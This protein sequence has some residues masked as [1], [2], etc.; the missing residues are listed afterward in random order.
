MAVSVNSG[1]Q[2]VVRTNS[3]S[4]TV[5]SGSNRYLRGIVNHE[6][7]ETQVPPTA[8]TWNG[9][10][11]TKVLEGKGTGGFNSSQM[12]ELKESDI[13]DT[14]L[15]GTFSVSGHS[16]PD[17][18]SLI[19]ICYNGVDQT[20]P[21]RDSAEVGL[22]GNNPDT[23][24]ILDI[25]D[26]DMVEYSYA[27]SGSLPITGWFNE[28]ASP[29]ATVQDDAG[30][31]PSEAG[32]KAYSG[33]DITDGQV[34]FSGGTFSRCPT[35]VA[36]LAES[37]G[38]TYTLSCD[39]GTFTQTGTAATLIKTHKIS[40]ATDQYD[41]TGVAASLEYGRVIDAE[42]VAYVLSGTAAS[43]EK[44]YKL[45]AESGTFIQIGTDA[46]LLKGYKI[47]P[48]NGPY[49][50][51]G[52]DVNLYRGYLVSAETTAYTYTGFP[53]TLIYSA[54]GD[55]SI[56]AESGTFVATG[57]DATL[58]LGRVLSAASTA[59]N[60]AGTDA[61][62]LKGRGLIAES[63]TFNLVGKDISLLSN[64]VLTPENGEYILTGFDVAD[65]FTLRE[66]VYLTTPITREKILA[67]S[68]TRTKELTN[69]ITREKVLSTKILQ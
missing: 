23:G 57:A 69:T 43:L 36:I 13:A 33:S 25:N 41:V 12:W 31:D 64:R 63:G 26:G 58:K 39:S 53:A 20:T 2:S 60:V 19:M 9:K 30:D 55:K 51:S 44:G 15:S 66:V 32:Y 18:V 34:N 4:F 38:T 28:I 27:S 42:T 67:T 52:Q 10:S 65:P 46:A 24:A 5:N 40:A 3:L 59:Y 37:T 61:D 6:G 35:C 56:I 22:T 11:M 68:I 47:S 7:P 16:T 14:D 54:S 17:Q 21:L 50:L 45:Q 49:V 8:A 29:T 48:E 62:L 1:Y